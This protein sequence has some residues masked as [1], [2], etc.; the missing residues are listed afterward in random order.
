[1]SLTTRWSLPTIGLATAV[2]ARGEPTAAPDL[3]ARPIASN[4]ATSKAANG[5]PSNAGPRNAEV[6]FLEIPQG[7][8]AQP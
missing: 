7:S 4:G 5:F 2:L 6:C 1:M 8:F 3:A